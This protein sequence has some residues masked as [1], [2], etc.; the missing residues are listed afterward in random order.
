MVDLDAKR[1]AVLSAGVDWH[2][3]FGSY[4]RRSA[5]GVARSLQLAAAVADDRAR[6][7]S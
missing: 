3:S 6:P 4:D 2:L 7:A 5:T 1:E